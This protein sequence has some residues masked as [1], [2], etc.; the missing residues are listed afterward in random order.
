MLGKEFIKTKLD[1]YKGDIKN[2]IE[3][4]INQILDAK[5]GPEEESKLAAQ[6]ED[7]GEEQ[8]EG[9]KE[10]QQLGPD[11]KRQNLERNLTQDTDQE[12]FDMLEKRKQT[13]MLHSQGESDHSGSS[14]HGPGKPMSGKSNSNMWQRNF[15]NHQGN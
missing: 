6:S 14:Y 11:E 7:V 9:K 15:D 8:G 1:Q 2:R 4:V 10:E 5:V 12:T 13:S 3:P